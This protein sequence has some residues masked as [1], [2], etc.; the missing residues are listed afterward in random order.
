MSWVVPFVAF[1][2]ASLDV[3]SLEGVLLGSSDAEVAA[4]AEE[5]ANTEDFVDVVLDTVEVNAMIPLEGVFSSVA[6]GCRTGP[7]DFFASVCGAA[8]SSRSA[9]LLV[10]WALEIGGSAGVVFAVLPACTTRSFLS[11]FAQSFLRAAS[12]LT[13][14]LGTAKVP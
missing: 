5:A 4:D 9:F 1:A 13:I 12:S 11:F 10:P 7:F 3:L 6:C 14:S 8:A 2:A